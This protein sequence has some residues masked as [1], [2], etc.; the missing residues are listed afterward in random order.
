MRIIGGKYKGRRID[1]PKGIEARPT[2]DYAKEGLFNIL[3]HSVPLEGIRLLDLFSG[4]G[5]ISLEFL[6]RGAENVL[7]VEQD[8]TLFTYQQALARKLEETNWQMVKAD[9]FSFLATHRGTY[10][11]IFADPPFRMEAF[12]RIPTLVRDGDLLAEDG[13]LI[14][15]HPGEVDLSNDPWFWKHRPYG[16]V[17]FSFFRRPTPTDPNPPA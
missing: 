12:D 4:T 9:V 17:H 7:S 8:R 2:T 1:P 13:L 15:E 11:I 3:Q 14:V 6:S 10:D 5:N 16:N